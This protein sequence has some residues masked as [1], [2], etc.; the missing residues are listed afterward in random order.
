MD[1]LCAH[2]KS[3][4]ESNKVVSILFGLGPGIPFTLFGGPF[5]FGTLMHLHFR[6]GIL[7]KKFSLAFVPVRVCE[8]R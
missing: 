1:V 6:L 8:P 3:E 2:R 4:I 5:I 7:A